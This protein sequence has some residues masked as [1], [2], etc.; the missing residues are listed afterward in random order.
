[1]VANRGGNE[2][3]FIAIDE[4]IFLDG[5]NE[6]NILPKEADPT[7]TT[8]VKSTT[9]TTPKQTTPTTTPVPSTEPPD[10]KIKYLYNMFTEWICLYLLAIIFC[11]FENDNYCH[12]N[13]NP[14]SVN[15]TQ[16]GW[17]RHTTKDLNGSD[18]PSPSGDFADSKDGHYIIASNKISMDAKNDAKGLFLSPFLIG[19]QH[20]EEC[21]TFKVYFSV[22][23]LCISQILRRKS[24]IFL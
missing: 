18:I 10:G 17:E 2:L 4:I 21:F 11:D 1:M 5:E 3:G 9:T 14:G 23:K 24:L 6:C 8:T 20:V 13:R 15:A 12:W 19:S 22:S 16:Y 7:L